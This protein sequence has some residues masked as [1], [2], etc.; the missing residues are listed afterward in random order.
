MT[1]IT[2]ISSVDLSEPFLNAAG[3]PGT[4]RRKH[5]STPRRRT[6]DCPTRFTLLLGLERPLHTRHPILLLLDHP[7][8]EAERARVVDIDAFR[9]KPQEVFAEMR[10]V[11]DW[12]SRKPH[13]EVRDETTALPER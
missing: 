12:M 8:H 5:R 3:D 1:L 11:A 10:L 9:D 7:F 2:P 4:K 6:H 13:G